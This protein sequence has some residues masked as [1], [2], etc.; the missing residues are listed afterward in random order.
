MK[1]II[2][3]IIA[4]VLLIGC[5]EED[6]NFDYISKYP[7]RA[8][9]VELSL[10]IAESDM[11]VCEEIGYTETI[12]LSDGNA[13][14]FPDLDETNLIQVYIDFFSYDRTN[15]VITEYERMSDFPYI[16]VSNTYRVFYH[17]ALK[18][19]LI[20]EACVYDLTRGTL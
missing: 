5:G 19:L 15:T 20:N 9:D 2:L 10:N 3:V 17:H 16:R 1:Q 13:F 4:A 6:K 7:N 18:Q 14:M 8:G 11:V 12:L